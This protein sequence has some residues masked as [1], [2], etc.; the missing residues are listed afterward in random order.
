MKLTKIKKLIKDEKLN[1]NKG[2]CA[3]TYFL[4]RHKDVNDFLSKFIERYTC[5][6]KVSDVLAWLKSGLKIKKCLNCGKRLSYRST[7]KGNLYCSLTCS[8]SQTGKIIKSQKIKESLNGKPNPFQLEEVKK[9]IRETNLKK[10]GVVNPMM[11][12][13]IS[14]LSA[15]RR[16]ES[17]DISSAQ[18][19]RGFDSFCNKLNKNNLTFCGDRDDYIGVNNGVVYKLHCNV[20]GSDFN[21]K[22]NNSKDYSFA[23]PKCHPYNRSNEEEELVKF[24]SKYVNVNIND[25]ITLDGC[26]NPELDIFIPEKRI[27]IEY[28]G[29]FWH[30]DEMGKDKNYHLK[31]LNDCNSKGIRLIHIFEDEWLYKKQIVKNRLKH[32]LGI[33]SASIGARK[34]EVREV[35]NSISN[36]FL[37]KHHIQGSIS[38]SICLGL[39]YK[40]R[41]IALM[42]FSHSRYNK[43]YEWELLRYCTMGSISVVGGASKLLS[44]FRSKYSGNIISYAD[45]R[46]S[47]GNLYKK[48]GF[49]EL[50]DSSPAYFYVK[51]KRRYSRVKFQKHK[52]KNVL[53][54]YDENLS[55]SQNMKNNGFQKIY[56]CGNKVFALK[57]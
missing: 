5:F 34:C 23:C 30:S 32:I 56:D 3:I 17:Y 42:T 50:K 21:Y 18:L 6:E 57:N 39:Y 26:K 40:N 7:K 47:D 55:E 1:A 44:H 24:I 15:K 13:E 35:S 8:T 12:K 49:E 53:E 51:N 2:G 54:N 37:E 33:H 16:K 10:Y 43:N 4:K 31:K 14:S 28:D 20:C 19:K 29:L 25:R 11:N 41:L 9:K 48:L 36:K 46:W 45:K 27:G 22:L 38:A 52:L